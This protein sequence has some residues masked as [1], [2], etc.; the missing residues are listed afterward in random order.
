MELHIG[1]FLI[2]SRIICMMECTCNMILGVD[3]H[4]GNPIWNRIKRAG[5][6]Q[7]LLPTMVHPMH[8]QQEPITN[9]R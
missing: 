8:H 2:T 6:I 3:K 1:G 4:H 9:G 5:I 7:V